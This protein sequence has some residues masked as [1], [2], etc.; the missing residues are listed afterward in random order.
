MNGLP[1]TGLK[2]QNM[3]DTAHAKTGLKLEELKNQ[4]DV[5]DDAETE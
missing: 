1:Q 3:V 2:G 5:N 4:Q